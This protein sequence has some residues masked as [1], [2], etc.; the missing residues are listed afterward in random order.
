MRTAQA[1]YSTARILGMLGAVAVWLYFLAWF[2]SS[3]EGDPSPQIT[4]AAAVVVLVIAVADVL[5]CVAAP[6]AVGAAV[7]RFSV[8]GIIVVAIAGLFFLPRDASELPVAFGTLS[9]LAPAWPSP[10]CCPSR[11]WAAATC[12]RGSGPWPASRSP[13]LQLWSCS[14]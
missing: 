1:A 9:F 5:L 12:G 7:V 3:P 8:I 13:S 2:I 4:N 14:R 6:S 11:S 10:S